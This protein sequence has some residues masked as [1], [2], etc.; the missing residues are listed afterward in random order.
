MFRVRVN[1]TGVSSPLVSTFNFLPNT[2][3]LAGANA[4][5]DAVATFMNSV[6]AAVGIAFSYVV[7]QQVD[8]ISN[9]GVKTGQFNGHVFGTAAG[10][11]AGDPLPQQT[12]GLINW[13]T[14]S[15]VAGREI[16]GRTF[17]PGPSESDSSAGIPTA[18]YQL[19]LQ[20]AANALVAESTAN[21]FV[22]SKKL[23]TIAEASSA[24]VAPG[25]RVLRSRR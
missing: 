16:R 9:A 21:L 6:R 18:A 25:W 15:F 7:N 24:S 19:I 8:V 10:T 3:D 20:N 11:A 17:I 14:L 13:H 5:G 12:Q 2:I 1:W 4:C 23:A 22:W